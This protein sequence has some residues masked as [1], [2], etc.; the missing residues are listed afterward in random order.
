MIKKIRSRY[1]DE[2]IITLLEDGSYKVEGK[3]LYT[4]HGVDLFDFEGGP[5]YIVGDKLL[6]VDDE[7]IIDSLKIDQSIVKENYAAVII[8]TRNAK[9]GKS[10]IR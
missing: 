6:D 10:K 7:V 9:R 5:C 8:T 2:R 3:S 1:G 4:R